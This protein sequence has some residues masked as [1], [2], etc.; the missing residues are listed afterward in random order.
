VRLAECPAHSGLPRQ[1]SH[2]Q[3]S[4]PVVPTGRTLAL[5][6]HNLESASPKLSAKEKRNESEKQPQSR[7]VIRRHSRLMFEDWGAGPRF[8]HTPKRGPALLVF[9]ARGQGFLGALVACRRTMIIRAGYLFIPLGRARLQPCRPELI[10]TR[11]LAPEGFLGPV[12]N[13]P[14][15]VTSSDLSQRFR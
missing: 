3:P 1:L 8:H 11:A 7:T 13:S 5:S 4:H 14:R 2:L 6:L 12:T 15:H 9:F 10:I